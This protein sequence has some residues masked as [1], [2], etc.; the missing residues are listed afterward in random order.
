LAGLARG[1]TSREIAW[2][3]F[4][5]TKTV[6]THCL[7]LKEKLRLDNINQLIAYAVRHET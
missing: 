7:H 4:I 1:Q 2:E 6:E 3:L 5:C